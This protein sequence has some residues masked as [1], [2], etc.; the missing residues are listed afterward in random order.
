LKQK[1]YKMARKTTNTTQ[2]TNPT[3]KNGMGM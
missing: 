3:A 2:P 1:P